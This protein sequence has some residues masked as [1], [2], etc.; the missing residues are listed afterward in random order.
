MKNGSDKFDF[1]DNFKFDSAKMTLF[2]W[3]EKAIKYIKADVDKILKE[4]KSKEILKE[5]K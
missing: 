5:V 2:E 1:V 4:K 3:I